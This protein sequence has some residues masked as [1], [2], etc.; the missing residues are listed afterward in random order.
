[1]FSWS[2]DS[3]CWSAWTTYDNYLRITNLLETD[4]YLRI[5]IS[6]VCNGVMLGNCITT[7]YTISVD[8]SNAFITDFCAETNLFQ[9]YNNLDCALQLQQQLAGFCSMYVWYTRLLL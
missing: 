9:P 5:L 7:D 2:S 3:V 4:F 8:S 1:M 6:T